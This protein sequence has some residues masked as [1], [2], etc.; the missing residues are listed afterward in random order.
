[1]QNLHEKKPDAYLFKAGYIWMGYKTTA[2]L[3][4]SICFK[5]KM[6]L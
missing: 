6:K 1:M 3:E 2:V 4:I 5:Q